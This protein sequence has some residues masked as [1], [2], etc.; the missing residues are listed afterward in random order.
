[1]QNGIMAISLWI[2]AFAGAVHN[3]SVN[4]VHDAN[5]QMQ[6]AKAASIQLSI[7]SQLCGYF[8]SLSLFQFVCFVC[9]AHRFWDFASN[10]HGGYMANLMTAMWIIFNKCFLLHNHNTWHPSRHTKCISA[11]QNV[12]HTHICAVFVDKIKIMNSTLCYFHPTHCLCNLLQH[13]MPCNY[14]ILN[15]YTIYIMKWSKYLRFQP[16][17][18][19]PMELFSTIQFDCLKLEWQ[20]IWWGIL[21]YFI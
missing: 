20:L 2:T 10:R 13:R 7:C 3:F 19:N 17:K 12:A 8:R 1:M 14:E 4:Y 15:W 6:F 18:Q 21:M 5:L 16:H 9:A 11:I